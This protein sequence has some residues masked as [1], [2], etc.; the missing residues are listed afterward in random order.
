MTQLANFVMHSL[1]K[2]SLVNNLV[3]Y[4]GLKPKRN[5]YDKGLDYTSN[6]LFF[7]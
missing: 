1:T 3:V 2:I 6:P 5:K 7:I 4:L